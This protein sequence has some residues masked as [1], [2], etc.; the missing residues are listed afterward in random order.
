MYASTLLFSGRNTAVE[1]KL[2]AAETALAAALQSTEPDERSQDLLG[3]IASMRATLAVIQHDVET[4]IAQSRRALKY[5]H[6]NNLTVRTATTWTLGYAYQLQGDRAAASQ[7]YTEVISLGKSFGNSIY[8]L[9]A[10]I[11]L[12]QIQEANNQL[13]LA[14]ESYRRSLQ[15]AGDPPQRM[16]CEAYL[17]LA[18]ITYEW[19][20]LDAAEQYG[21]QSAQLARQ[22]I[23]DTFA[24]YGVFVA[25]LRL[26]Q[27]DV[28]GAV[29]TLGEAEE[30]V[31]RY[32]FAFRMPDV[33]AAQVLTLLRQDSLS[34][35]AHLAQTHELP[36]S[37]ARVHL[38]QG[39]PSSALSVLE[40]LQQQADAKNWQD[41][42]LKVMV[43]QSLALHA[44]GENDK[45]VQLLCGALGLAEPGGFL[46]IFVDEG[47]PM[48]QL[49]SKAAA[50]GI[51]LDYIG[52]LLAAFEAG[53]QKSEDKSSLPSTSSGQPL[54]DPLSQRELE[55][56]KLIAQGLSNHEISERLFLA[57]STVKGHNR[58]IFGKLH[59]QRRT[60]AIVRARE[61]G[62]L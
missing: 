53:K 54:I 37:Q 49:L 21:Q 45:A 47:L 22:L 34:A 43:L 19:N 52:K 10:T 50:R 3:R 31:R 57:L 5:L 44:H 41:E 51:K 16:V 15:L 1:Q 8:T 61:L 46:R 30:F 32:N 11:N 58:I 4:I 9:A 62:L 59:V 29:A 48:A 6:P 36:I 28:P 18:R 60:E 42:R 14:A 39:D 33:V 23:V 55:V 56:L 24:A 17:G 26:A 38:A 2:Q 7:A 20:D 25:R 27:G 12:G 40:P 35:A 13:Y